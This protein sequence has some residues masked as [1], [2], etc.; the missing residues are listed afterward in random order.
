[1]MTNKKAAF[2]IV[3]SEVEAE[4]LLDALRA[5]GFRM[6][7][8]SVLL[9]GR[10]ATRDFVHAQGTKAPEG[11]IVGGGAGGAVGGTLGLL[12]GLG[13]LAIPGL[14]PLLAA[15]PIFAA[16]SGA[17]VGAAVGGVAGGLVGLGIPEIQARL[18][19]GKIRSGNVLVSIHGDDSERI[20][21]A[22]RV[23]TSFGAADI[24]VTHEWSV[25]TREALDQRVHTTR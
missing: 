16:L 11:A 15:G 20:E 23:L 10:G 22:K 2:G 24:S 17:A 19:E 3:R 8:V 12:A 6:S 4:R 9:P 25:P 13:A 21:S 5:A 18:Y 14:G 7:D 1:M